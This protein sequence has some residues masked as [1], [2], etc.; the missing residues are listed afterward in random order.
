MF[1][2][3]GYDPSWNLDL[4]QGDQKTEHNESVW[5]CLPKLLLF[6]RPTRFLVNSHLLCLT[7]QVPTG[8]FRDPYSFNKIS[9]L[10]MRG[11]FY[12]VLC[13][14]RALTYI[15]RARPSKAT[16][17]FA[18]KQLATGA[19]IYC[20]YNKSWARLNICHV[21]FILALWLLTPLQ[22]SFDLLP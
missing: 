19:A 15:L 4:E 18:A 16:I 3:W 12:F 11:R 6:L 14:L 21:L 8:F 22:P 5:T 9:I 2:H 13:N 1:L 7:L 20:S 17:A 10:C